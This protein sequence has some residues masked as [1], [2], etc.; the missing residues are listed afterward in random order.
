MADDI[1]YGAIS[2]YKVG[3]LGFVEE[4][5]KRRATPQLHGLPLPEGTISRALGK[6]FRPEKVTLLAGHSNHGKSI[7]AQQLTFHAAR[8]FAE[9]NQDLADPETGEMRKPQA[10]VYFTV[11]MPWTELLA[12]AIT[13]ICG[14]DN[15]KLMD[16][17]DIDEAAGDWGTIEAGLMMIEDLPVYI[18][19]DPQLSITSIE[20]YLAALRR[21]AD[22]RLVVIDYLQIMDS[23]GTSENENLRLKQIS[24]RVKRIARQLQCH[25]I[26][27]SSLN[28]RGDGFLPTLQ[29]I[30]N[31]GDI[32]FNVD[33]VVF[34]HQPYLADHRVGDAWEGVAVFS[35]GKNRAGKVGEYKLKWNEGFLKFEDLDHY[36]E[37]NLPELPTS[38]FGI[39]G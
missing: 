7:I 10:V 24:Q 28:Q 38:R 32:V 25:I 6:K 8:V 39:R 18:V 23:S 9:R 21:E 27:I 14:F 30:R 11:E 12:R 34:L 26:L 37:S 2:N 19:D 15:G 20:K 35:V 1:D 22:V 3:A 13:Q 5:K 16:P 29:N 36:D 33:T 31:S 4:L 17:E